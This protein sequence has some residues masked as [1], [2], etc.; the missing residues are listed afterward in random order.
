[1]VAAG[2]R[3]AGVG[4]EVA[5]LREIRSWVWSFSGG[6]DTYA[7]VLDADVEVASGDTAGVVYWS[8]CGWAG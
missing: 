5:A 4:G 2:A 7:E 8:C 6:W 1:M 3:A